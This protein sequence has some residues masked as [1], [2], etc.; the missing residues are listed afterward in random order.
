MKT[1]KDEANF[2]CVVAG[3]IVNKYKLWRFNNKSI[4]FKTMGHNKSKQV[5][6]NKKR[7]FKL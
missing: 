1:H 2:K 4:S 5:A 3:H 6:K 7:Q